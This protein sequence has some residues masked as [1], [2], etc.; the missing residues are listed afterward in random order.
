ML[1]RHAPLSTLASL[2]G[3]GVAVIASASAS[4]RASDAVLSSAETPLA[5]ATLR[6]V[7]VSDVVRVDGGTLLYA[8]GTSGLRVVDVRDAVHPRV[9]STVPFVGTP[10]ALFA[11]E[12]IAWVV[13]VDWDSRSGMRGPATVIRAVD[14]RDASAPRVLGNEVREGTARTAKLVGSLL[15]VLRPEGD[16]SVVEAFG[17]KRGRLVPLESARLEGAPAQLAASS[18]GLAAATDSADH[19]TVTWIDLSMKRPGSL[20][21]HEPIRLPGGVATG[22]QGDARIIDADDGQRVRIVTC[23][24]R[25]CAVGEPATLRIVDFSARAPAR[26]LTSL[27][28]TEHGGLPL[29][30]FADGVLYVAERDASRPDASTLR[31]V[32]T[33]ERVP[34][35]AARVPLRGRVSTLVPHDETLVAIGTIGSRESAVKVIVHDIDVRRPA[36]PHARGEVTFG[37]DWTATA[38]E[39]AEQAV[40]FDPA[41]RLVA[42]PF[43]AWRRGAARS[44]SGAQLVD[45]SPF[46]PRTAGTIAMDGYV[47]RAVFLEGELVTIGPDGVTSIDAAA[48]RGPDLE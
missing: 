43:T 48:T 7:G 15:Y 22:E 20:E 41:S 42:L 19:A 18:A 39:D 47:E 45:L 34:R 27:R 36:E 40:S 32:L 46:G 33:D 25:S 26:T 14:V 38:A 4:A 30:R 23:A 2:L 37:S 21:P 17:L 24:T 13:F 35:I 5:C 11:N 10:I 44:F 9:T 8:D 1:G 29:S 28:L 6:A 3:V 12:G 16:R 31:V